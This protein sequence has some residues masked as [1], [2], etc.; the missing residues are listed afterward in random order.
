MNSNDI[1]MS[2]TD[3]KKKVIDH[4]V[5][6]MPEGGK[7]GKFNGKGEYPHIVEIPGKSQREVI[8]TI[9]KGD[10]VSEV[11]EF[12]NLSFSNSYT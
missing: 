8:E 11:A 3:F 5:A 4:L 1:I 2:Y 9:L 7:P 6:Y 10:G 12:K